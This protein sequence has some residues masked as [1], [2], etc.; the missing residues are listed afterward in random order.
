MVRNWNKLPCDV[1]DVLSFET[2]KVRLD[3]VISTLIYL[4]CSCSLQESWTG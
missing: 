4:W 1:V 3:Q 2:S